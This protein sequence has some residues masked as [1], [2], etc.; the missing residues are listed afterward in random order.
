MEND[1]KWSTQKTIM[2]QAGII[3]LTI[4]KQEHGDIEERL[5]KIEERLPSALDNR[6]LRFEEFEA[7]ISHVICTSATPGDYEKEKAGAVV[8][9]IIRPTGL[10]D[11]IIEVRSNNLNPVYDVMEEIKKRIAKNERVTMCSE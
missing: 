3:K 2:F 7:K 11:P 9:Q 4:D 1:I 6:P 5:N 8:E 10:L